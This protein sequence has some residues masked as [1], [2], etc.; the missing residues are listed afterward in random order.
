MKFVYDKF[1]V[2]NKLMVQ[3]KVVFESKIEFDVFF[4]SVKVYFVEFGK[5]IC[6][7]MDDMYF[8][9]VFNLFKEINLVDCELLGLDF[10]EG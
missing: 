5:Y 8:F 1:V 10:V 4:E 7:V 6:C 2:Y 9:K 3:K